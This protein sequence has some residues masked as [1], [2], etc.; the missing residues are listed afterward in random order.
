M[1][2][3]LIK[4]LDEWTRE[5]DRGLFDERVENG[6]FGTGEGESDFELVNE[7]EFD[8]TMVDKVSLSISDLRFSGLDLVK[9]T[10]SWCSI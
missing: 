10:F 4:G 1:N 6:V 2:D 5:L 3:W 9:E 8:N 7:G